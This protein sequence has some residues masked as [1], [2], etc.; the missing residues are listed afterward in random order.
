MIFESLEADCY[1]RH[2]IL[3]N[4][5]L[6]LSLNKPTSLT[7][8]VLLSPWPHTGHVSADAAEDVVDD[9]DAAVDE[10]EE[11]DEDEVLVEED[12]MQATVCIS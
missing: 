11:D 2:V 8:S 1:S 6:L 10:E 4:L 12:Q 3:Y 9:H 5:S 7:R